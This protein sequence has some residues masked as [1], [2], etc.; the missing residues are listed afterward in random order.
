[1]IIF[2]L[3]PADDPATDRGALSGQPSDM[4]GLGSFR[5]GRQME[6]IR[7]AKKPKIATGQPAGSFRF[8][9]LKVHQIPALFFT[10]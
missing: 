7:L 10:K 2:S 6:S 8:Y 4:P 5:P 9:G 3:R 1:V